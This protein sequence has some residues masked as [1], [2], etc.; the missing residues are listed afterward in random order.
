MLGQ[1]QDMFQDVCGWNPLL[2]MGLGVVM[3][4]G[5]FETILDCWISNDAPDVHLWL[6]FG[7]ATFSFDAHDSWWEKYL[8]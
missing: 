1:L 7:V 8:K 4:P 6:I 2:S 5:A 3:Q